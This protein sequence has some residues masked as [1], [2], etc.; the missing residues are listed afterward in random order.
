MRLARDI[1]VIEGALGDG[2]KRIYDGEIPLI[3]RLRRV[4]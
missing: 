4:A 2:R 3:K 1:R